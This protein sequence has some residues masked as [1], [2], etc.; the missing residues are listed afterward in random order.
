VTADV[1]SKSN[2]IILALWDVCIYT[3]GTIY[4]RTIAVLKSACAWFK[5]EHRTNSFDYMLADREEHR[6]NGFRLYAGC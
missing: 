4:L 6:T 3:F 2:G 1:R 5:N